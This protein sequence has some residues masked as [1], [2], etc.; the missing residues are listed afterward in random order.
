[1][2][3]TIA[4][5]TLNKPGVLARI[6]GLLSRRVFNIESIA[7]GHTEEPDVTRITVVVEGDEQASDQVM[8]Q[9]SKLIDVVKI[10]EL[11]SSE[12][13]ERELA[14]IKVKADQTRRSNVVDVVEIFRANIVDVNRETVTI[15]LTGDEEK[16]N[17]LCAVLEEHEIVEMVRTGKIALSRGSGATKYIEYED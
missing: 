8:K 1:M 6:A 13:I 2:K 7:A 9:L 3:R 14:L 11:K 17:A 16:I 5:L 15:E 4:V 12:S 10:Q